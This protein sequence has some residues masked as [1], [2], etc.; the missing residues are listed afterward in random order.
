MLSGVGPTESLKRLNIDVIQPL[1]GV[2][3]NLQDHPDYSVVIKGKNHE[4]A[5]FS[6][7]TFARNVKH[8][9]QYIKHKSGLLSQSISEVG[10][11]IKSSPE[12]KHADIQLHFMP[13]QLYDHGR[14]FKKLLQKGYS[15]RVS[16]LKPD[17]RG[18]VELTSHNPNDAPLITYNLLAKSDDITRLL[19]GIK[20]VRELFN[21]SHFK[22]YRVN[23]FM[24]GDEIQ[25]DAGL[26]HSIRNNVNTIY[27]AVGT[28]KMGN[29][30]DAV[31]SQQLKVHGIDKLYIADASI[32]PNTVSGNTNATV[33]MI[34]EKAADILL[35]TINASE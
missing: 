27:H 1:D 10:G 13:I 9:Y 34:A 17:S 4:G 3:K 24:P 8:S 35:K 25:T 18:T 14:D 16:L 6:P 11:F 12:L 31:V 32:M 15:C 28:C 20:Q 23:E 7:K 29:S 22:P 33:Y 5:H 21:H 30:T 2:G 19:S 26:K